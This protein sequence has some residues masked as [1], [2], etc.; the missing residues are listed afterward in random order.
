M[1]ILREQRELRLFR[2]GFQ[3]I[4]SDFSKKKKGLGVLNIFI[5]WVVA[6]FYKGEGYLVDAMAI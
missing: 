6:K 3:N 4:V 5:R 2:L 1:Q